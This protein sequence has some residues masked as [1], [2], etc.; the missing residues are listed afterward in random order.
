[1]TLE[2]SGQIGDSWFSGP[3][4][5]NFRHPQT[6]DIWSDRHFPPDNLTHQILSGAGEWRVVYTV[7]VF[8]PFQTEPRNWVVSVITAVSDY[9]DI[10]ELPVAKTSI[11][12]RV[13]VPTIGS[14]QADFLETISAVTTGF[15]DRECEPDGTG[16]WRWMAGS[17]RISIRN[18]RNDCILELDSRIP[19]NLPALLRIKVN[20]MELPPVQQLDNH[21][22]IQ[23][24]IP[25]EWLGNEDNISLSFEVDDTFI[26]ASD[27]KSTDKRELGMMIHS[28]ALCLKTD[29]SDCHSIYDL[30]EETR[31]FESWRQVKE[32][33][34]LIIK[35]PGKPIDFF[36]KCWIPED[37]LITGTTLQIR[38][39]SSEVFSTAVQ[40]GEFPVFLQIPV[41]ALGVDP[42]VG[43]TIDT[44]LKMII[45]RLW[46]H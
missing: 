21:I 14:G 5:L 13:I 39:N 3:V 31:V 20:N 29:W 45:T 32:P 7:P 1:M 35:N 10:F 34:H 25:V 15:Y 44:S 26:P 40:S 23:R 16:C 18:P 33:C 36:V 27:G 28:L 17:G 46:I 43:V 12:Q 30:I 11:Y 9:P 41:E 38:L 37:A 19:D 2:W 6:G 42:E 24:E 8:F 22:F 4:T